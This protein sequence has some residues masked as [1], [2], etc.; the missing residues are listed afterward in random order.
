MKQIIILVIL[1][2]IILFSCS[3][4]K[5]DVDYIVNSKEASNYRKKS[6]EIMT[7]ILD[8]KIQLDKVIFFLKTIP[9]RN[10]T[11]LQLTEVLSKS[12][13]S[14]EDKAYVSDLYEESR[15]YNVLIQKFPDVRQF[16]ITD[17][18]MVL[19]GKEGFNYD[20]RKLLVKQSNN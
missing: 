11:K 1:F 18:R 3:N 6:F 13:L 17:R 9:D 19:N 5:V 2:P 7:N 20:W 14:T 15:L 4:E 10:Y 16:N 12:D 8:D